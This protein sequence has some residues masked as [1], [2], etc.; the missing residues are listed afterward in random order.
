MKPNTYRS[1]QT[2]LSVTK[3]EQDMTPDNP[4]KVWRKTGIAKD[5][6]IHGYRTSF[7]T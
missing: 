5:T 6:T 2:F 4:M 1:D 3:P 7:R